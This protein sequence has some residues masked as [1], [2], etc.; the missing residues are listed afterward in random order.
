MNAG[1]DKEGAVAQ[2]N[3]SLTESQSRAKEML[4]QISDL[5]QEQDK[6]AKALAATQKSLSDSEKQRAELQKASLTTNQQLSDKTT[7]LAALGANLSASEAKLTQ[8][9][10]SLD[11]NQKHALDQDE[12]VAALAAENSLKEKAIADAQKALTDNENQRNELKKKWDDASSK[13]DDQDKQLASLRSELKAA[14]TGAPTPQTKEDVRAYSLGAFWGQ[15]VLSSLNKMEAEGL[16]LSR[17][18]VANGVADFLQG[19]FK[20]PKEKM[21]ASLKEMDTEVSTHPTEAKKEVSND[22]GQNYMT[23]F[24]KQPGAKKA[25]MGY[26]YRVMEK[27]KGKINKTDTVA[28]VV[29]ESLAGGKV[30]KDMSKMGKALVLPLD[31]FPPLFQSA[32]IKM[33]K[34]GRLQMVVPPELAYGEEGSAPDIPPNATMVYE[35]QIVNVN[36][37]LK[38]H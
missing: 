30:I 29:K 28:I 36:P 34:Q 37:E 24:S 12:K 2:L 26:Y 17:Q 22:K 14:S 31:K 4:K 19:K 6:Q 27:G 25:E 3:K 8:L 33:N 20:I 21:V 10:K 7:E 11:G 15:E 16:T 18:H 35:I 1:A 13:L 9:Q 5:K 38:T 32:I 23:T